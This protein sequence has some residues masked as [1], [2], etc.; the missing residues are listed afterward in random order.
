MTIKELITKLKDYNLHAN[1]EIIV[2]NRVVD[3]S[4]TY[5]DNEGVTKGNCSTVGFYVDELCGSE[6]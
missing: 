2:H 4:I 1:V 6:K 5:G 3:F